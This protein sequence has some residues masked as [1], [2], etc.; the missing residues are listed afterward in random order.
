[1][2]DQCVFIRGFRAKRILF[3]ARRIRAAAGP[4]PDD[5]DNQPEDE[6][7]VSR[8]PGGEKVGILPLS[9]DFWRGHD[10]LVSES[11]STRR[12]F[13]LYCRG[14]S[15]WIRLFASI[16]LSGPP[17]K[18]QSDDVEEG[19]LA[20]AHYDDLQLIDDVVCSSQNAGI[21][22]LIYRQYARPGNHDCG[23]NPG[24]FT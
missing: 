6:I 21:Y 1:M 16:V 9:Y 13:G 18:C 23:R 4:R 17:K 3:W 22:T 15:A 2:A 5:P 7:E 10:D 24:V 20:I 11:R 14:S 8:V 19:I 12:R